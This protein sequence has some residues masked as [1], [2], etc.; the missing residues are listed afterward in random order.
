MQLIDHTFKVPEHNLA[1]DEALLE[2]CEDDY[3]RE[4]LRFW[5]PEQYFVVLGY[6]AKSNLE[7]NIPLCRAKQIPILRR[8]SGG[9]T[10]L[11]GPGCLNYSLILKMSNSRSLKN[12]VETNAYIMDRHK[13]ALKP[14][15]GT[16]LAVRGFTDLVVGQQKFSGNAQRRK[17]KFLLFHGTFL[18][19]FDIHLAEALLPI[20][21]KQPLYRK[22]R[23]HLD[24]LTNINVPSQNI[25]ATLQKVWNAHEPF[26]QIPVQKIDE[27]VKEKYTRN[28]WNFK[29]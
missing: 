13:E 20:P 12:I 28:E 17:K 11:Q 9:G 1:C 21:S 6:A 5:E 18:L 22:N 26:T 15:I 14:M 3:D 29:F 27:L 10:V 19:N 2:F 8:S 23:P 4:I 24:F 7:V 25:K 16:Q